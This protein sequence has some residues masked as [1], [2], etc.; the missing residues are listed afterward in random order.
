MN[1]IFRMNTAIYGGGSA[2]YVGAPLFLS[3]VFFNNS[4]TD[5]GVVWNDYNSNPT[6]VNCLI[7]G[8]SATRAGGGAYSH[9]S[10]TLS[11]TNC[12]L[13]GNQS[14]EGNAFAFDSYYQVYPST[15][16]ITNCIVWDNGAEIWN[17]DNSLMNITC[18]DIFGGWAGVGN[19]AS[20]PKFVRLP[21]GTDP[22]DLH[23]KAGSPCLDAGNSLALPADVMDLD[24]DG[25]TAEPIPFD[26]DGAARVQGT[27]VDMG[28]YEGCASPPLAAIVDITPD[29][30]NKRSNGQWVTAF[31]MLPAG[32]DVLA[33]DDSSIA[34]T[35]IQGTAG[36]TCSPDTT[37]QPR[38]MGFVPQVGDHDE[39][40]IPDLMVKFNRQLLQGR[41]CIDDQ[42]ITVSGTLTTGE[43]FIGSD[44]IRVIDRVK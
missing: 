33:I 34:I 4:A 23:L 25:D 2:N 43:L 5:G 30:L 14:P 6:F 22:G 40:G 18:T 8:N 7:A 11:L 13:T 35:G 12:T 32:Y 17:N 36:S 24:G 3:C 16:N 39:D 1:S 19:I 10:T 41:L 21:G 27:A 9:N 42:T 28:A 15:L 37:V 38:D 29:T 20:D 26:L 44:T 31:I